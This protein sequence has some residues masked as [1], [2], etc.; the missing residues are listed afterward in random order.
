M[1]WE[2][3]EKTLYKIINI[4]IFSIQSTVFLMKATAFD[5]HNQLLNYTKW[6]GL[7]V[8]SGMLIHPLKSLYWLKEATC[9]ENDM[10]DSYIWRTMNVYPSSQCRCGRNLHVQ[11]QKWIALPVQTQT[12]AFQDIMRPQ[13]SWHIGEINHLIPHVSLLCTVA[14]RQTEPQK[15][16]NWGHVVFGDCILWHI[17]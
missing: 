1:T 7:T 3:A 12:P 2:I 14:L 8:V 15:R 11:F 6:R 17:Y 16:L 5:N 4:W 13:R 10:D 9:C